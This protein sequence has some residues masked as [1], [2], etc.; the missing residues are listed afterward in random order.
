M[1]QHILLPTDGSDAAM[2]AV[3]RGVELAARLGA[4]VT[5]MTALEHF[6]A[7]IM[8]SAYRPGDE[9]REAPGVQVA[10]HR[11]ELAEAVARKAGVAC[12]RILVREHMP[13][14]RAILD[15]AQSSGADLIVM[16]THG[17]GLMERIFVG[18]QTQRVLAHTQIPVLTLH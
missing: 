17:M 13:V 2:R 3:E 5:V 9:P 8:A 12:Q 15:A 6:P 1:F 4:R 10:E 16:G 7:H 11:L 14:F 18:S